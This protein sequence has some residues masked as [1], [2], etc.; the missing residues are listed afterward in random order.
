MVSQDHY[1][2]ARDVRAPTM[3]ASPV[4]DT[5]ARPPSVSNA[6]ARPNRRPAE[7][8]PELA[9]VTVPTRDALVAYPD[10]AGRLASHL[11][12]G[13]R[14][15]GPWSATRDAGLLLVSRPYLDAV[16]VW[17]YPDDAAAAGYA[18]LTRLARRGRHSTVPVAEIIGAA[19]IEPATA[20][21]ATVKVAA[22]V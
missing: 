17:T 15:V 7:P 6:Q 8:R 14:V 4:S 21:A 10:L 18:L 16:E 9:T 3:G 19:R 1:G 2:K 20:V 5:Q 22:E 13:G 11:A 12:M